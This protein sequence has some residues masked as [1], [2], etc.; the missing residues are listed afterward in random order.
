M[1]V[2]NLTEDALE[3]K[4][5]EW[6]R[7][8]HEHPEVSTEEKKTSEK[9][10][11]ILKDLGLDPVRGTDHYG[12]AATLKGGKPGPMVA[13]RADIDALSVK[14]AT[15]LPYASQNPGV[16]HA[17]GHDVHTTNLLAVC[18]ILNRTKDQWKG[19]VR[20]VSSRQ[21]KMAAVVGK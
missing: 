21:R 6:R 10:F 13:L 4:C 18:D 14:E 8:F 5:V 16:M 19:R 15:G 7:W 11:T 20:A 2:L 3:A 9:I 1:D 17:C 12:V